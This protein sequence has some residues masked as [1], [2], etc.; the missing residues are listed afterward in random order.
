MV[1]CPRA[2]MSACGNWESL[3]DAGIATISGN[4]QRLFPEIKAGLGFSKSKSF[5][6]GIG[7]EN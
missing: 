4:N 7:Q 2:P 3:W 6:H 5:S 1:L